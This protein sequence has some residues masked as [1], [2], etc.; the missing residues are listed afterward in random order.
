MPTDLWRFAETLYQRPHIEPA[1]LQLQAQGADVCLLLCGAWL[2]VH[3]VACADARITVLRNLAQPWQQEVIEPL[4]QLRKSW[5]E[6]A[7]L[8]PVLAQLREQIKRLELEAEQTLL[9]RLGA[10][11]QDWPRAAANASWQWL[12]RMAPTAANRDAL[13]TLRITAAQL[14][15]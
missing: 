8:D 4:R 7:Q 15:I 13:Q 11:S 2:E 14:R 3:Q 9:D 6:Q 1:C 5:R 10:C 12:E